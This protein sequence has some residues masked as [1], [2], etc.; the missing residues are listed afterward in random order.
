MWAKAVLKRPGERPGG[1]KTQTTI[2]FSP[3]V[4]EFFKV[5][6][7]GYQTRMNQVLLRYVR[8]QKAKKIK[9]A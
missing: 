4:V 3:E 2:R 5:Q 9:A 7:P 6:G 1:Q 8:R